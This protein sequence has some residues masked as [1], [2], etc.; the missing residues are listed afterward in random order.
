LAYCA[1]FT[2]NTGNNNVFLDQVRTQN[3]SNLSSWLTCT[4]ASQQTPVQWTWAGSTNCAPDV[5]VVSNDGSG[6]QA[7]LLL[8]T[9]ADP[10]GCCGTAISSGSAGANNSAGGFNFAPTT[11]VY[12]EALIRL[13]PSE[14]ASAVPSV[15]TSDLAAFWSYFRQKFGGCCNG[16]G[17]I[18]NDTYEQGFV[19]PSRSGADLEIHNS[20]GNATSAGG[21]DQRPPQ[22]DGNTHL[23]GGLATGN[24][25]VS[26]FIALCAYT[27]GVA[28]PS[29]CM[30]GGNFN[31]DPTSFQ[32]EGVIILANNAGIS[33][34]LLA[35]VHVYVEGVRW[36]SC[37]GW[38]SQGAGVAT[39]NTTTN[40]CVPTHVFGGT[41]P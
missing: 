2:K 38:K 3:W 20:F 11:N 10:A 29:T 35:N 25:S 39:D 7:L 14:W 34:P 31:N 33:A 32:Q 40:N 37:S 16:D 17:N 18:E 12:Q 19:P 8:N 27:D 36:W 21:N 26:P 13:V 1:D 30:N 4:P 28:T 9:P 22:T 23:I 6:K 5:Q 15:G 41:A 24:G